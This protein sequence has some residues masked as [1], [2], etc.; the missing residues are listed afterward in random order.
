[1]AKLTIIVGLPGSGKSER[2]L[3]LAH[4]CDGI[5]IEDFMRDSR[6][7]SHR[8]PDSQHYHA[9]IMTLRA[10]FDCII[11][12][13]AFCDTGRRLEAEQILR[14]DVPNLTIAWIFYANDAETCQANIRRRNRDTL[15]HD[16]LMIAEFMH[17]Y[18]IPPEVH[19]EPVW[20]ADL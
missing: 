20:K 14:H 5:C 4:S 16:E 1:M 6:H 12:D 9:L 10:G 19:V 15:P 8:F 3:E 17:K 18:F 13:I 11:A 2:M 7:S